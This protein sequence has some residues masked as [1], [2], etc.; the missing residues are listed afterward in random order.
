MRELGPQTDQV[1]VLFITIDP[2]R[3]TQALLKSY[4]PGIY[5]FI[6]PTGS[7]AQIASVAGNSRCIAVRMAPMAITPWTTVPGLTC[8]TGMEMRVL[9]VPYGSGAATFTTICVHCCHG[10]AIP[11]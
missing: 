7:P 10:S 3:D 1:Q 8:W 4:A 2:A 11:I 9:E 6:G 5:C